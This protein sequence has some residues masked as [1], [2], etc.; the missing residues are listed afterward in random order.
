M[1]E[2]RLA[3]CGWGLLEAPCRAGGD[4]TSSGALNLKL[5]MLNEL[6]LRC[7]ASEAD[8]RSEEALV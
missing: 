1:R 5:R 3:T 4:V 6:R 2:S 8:V 7:D